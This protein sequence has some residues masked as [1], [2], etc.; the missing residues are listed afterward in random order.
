MSAWKKST[1]FRSIGIYIGGISRGC[2][3][4]K[5]P[6][7]WVRT[8]VHGGRHPLPIWVGKQAPCTAFAHRMPNKAGTARSQGVD[9]AQAAVKRAKSLSIGKGSVLYL[10]VEAYDSGNSTCRRAVLSH[11]SGWVNELDRQGYRSGVCS[12]AGSGIGDL[13]DTYHS[14][15]YA[16]PNHM[17]AAWW[18]G[19]ADTALKPYVPDGQW[20]N[21]QRVHQYRGGHSETHGGHTLNIDSDYLS[22]H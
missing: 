2:A 11:V 15:S 18:N 22:V 12:S 13:S 8:R 5:L 14:T 3:Q 10:D 20:N 4:P 9:S 7:D 17:W 6:A 21:R 1:N 19:K 16:R